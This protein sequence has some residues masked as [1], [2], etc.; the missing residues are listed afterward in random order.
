M[1][2][3]CDK[4]NCKTFQFYLVTVNVF[5][6]SSFALY[7]IPLYCSISNVHDHEK[8]YFAVGKISHA[9][10]GR[11]A[12]V[13]ALSAASG[14]LTSTI[15]SGVVQVNFYYLIHCVFACR[16]SKYLSL[17]LYN[18]L[19]HAKCAYLLLTVEFYVWSYY[20][21]TSNL[22]ILKNKSPTVYI[23]CYKI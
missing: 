8:S 3:L 23:S 19:V 7:G 11:I 16:S 9:A 21:Q 5:S 17:K 14:G 20:W 12:L 6:F 4:G 13:M 15:V 10:V 22:H 18:W 1:F 2:Y